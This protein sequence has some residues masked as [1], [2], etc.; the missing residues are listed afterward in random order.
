MLGVLGAD[1]GRAWGPAEHPYPSSGCCGDLG[2]CR[3]RQAGHQIG[4]GV[5]EVQQQS[6]GSEQRQQIPSSLDS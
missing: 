3:G 5:S 1:A 4:R 6:S 2:Q